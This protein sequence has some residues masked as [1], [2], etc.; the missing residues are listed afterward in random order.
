MHTCCSLTQ[1]Y[2]L[3]YDIFDLW[4]LFKHRHRTGWR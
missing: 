2:L 3:T 1:K 4:H